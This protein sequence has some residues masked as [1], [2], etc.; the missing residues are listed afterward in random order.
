MQAIHIFIYNFYPLINLS[1]WYKLCFMG[2]PTKI[3][4]CLCLKRDR[5][6]TSVMHSRRLICF[7][8]IVRI[9]KSY[10]VYNMLL[11]ILDSSIISKLF[12][13]LYYHPL[14]YKLYQCYHN[15]NIWYPVAN[16]NKSVFGLSIFIFN[17]LQHF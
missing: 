8:K 15:K 12:E 14:Y 1:S 17:I 9:S 13:T 6:S 16:Q 11:F 10:F 5:D 2:P 4:C 7:Q 3:T